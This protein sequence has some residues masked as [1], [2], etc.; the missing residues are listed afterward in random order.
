MATRRG[1]RLPLLAHGAEG[2]RPS[3]ATAESAGSV[4]TC[5][6][7]AGKQE[8]RFPEEGR[9]AETGKPETGGLGAYALR[10]HSRQRGKEEQG[11][12]AGFPPKF[13]ALFTNT[14]VVVDLQS[15]LKA[16]SRERRCR[17]RKGGRERAGGRREGGR[18]GGG[19]GIW[20]G[21]SALFLKLSILSTPIVRASCKTSRA[22]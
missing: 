14:A 12:V 9:K 16:T 21:Q 10:R 3:P 13:P 8:S 19:L 11:S 1:L 22:F 18:E 17:Q 4:A 5:D 6:A 15:T 7:P 2:K 20:K